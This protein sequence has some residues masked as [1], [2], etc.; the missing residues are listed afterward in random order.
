MAD[1][2]CGLQ[3]R[4]DETRMTGRTGIYLFW[5]LMILGEASMPLASAQTRS[6]TMN[7]SLIEVDRLA[8]D[9]GE[10]QAV[11]LV[12]ECS[13]IFVRVGATVPITVNVVTPG[14][15]ILNETNLGAFG[16]TLDSLAFEGTGPGQ[17]ILPDYIPGFR[18]V[19]TFPSFGPGAY[20][21]RFAS[22]STLSS[23][24]AVITQLD[25]DSPIRTSLISTASTGP[26]SRSKRV[27]LRR[28]NRGAQCGC[29]C[30]RQRRRRRCH[31]S[32]I[33]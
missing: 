16:G 14:G 17:L 24:A 30:R 3:K 32:R 15:D 13:S 9:V 26:R 4:A 33:A 12:D 25:T 6:A 29:E 18:Y 20:T 27:C 22:A 7:G 1:R 28:R 11:F 8:P 21:V 5:G 19:V 23:E 10:G 2:C 31:E